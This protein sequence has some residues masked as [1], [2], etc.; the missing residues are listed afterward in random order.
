MVLTALFLFPRLALGLSG[1]ETGVVVMPLVKV[2]GRQPG[3]AGL[4][5]P[6]HRPLADAGG[7]HHECVLADEQRGNHPAHPA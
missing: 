6:Q 7:L 5:H 4:P 3:A 2:S 1:F